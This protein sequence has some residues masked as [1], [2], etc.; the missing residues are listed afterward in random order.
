VPEPSKFKTGD[1][2]YLKGGGFKMTVGLVKLSDDDIVL[3]DCDWHDQNGI[4]HH[5]DYFED[6]LL[7]ADELA[8]EAGVFE[9]RFPE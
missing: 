6:Q 7:A 5:W 8:R 9:Q 3:C 2:V 1:V 4:A